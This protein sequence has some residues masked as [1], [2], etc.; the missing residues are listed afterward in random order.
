ME[1]IEGT[2]DEVAAASERLTATVAKVTDEDLRRPSRLPG[3]TRGHLLAHLVRNTDSCWNLLEWART[4]SEF[5][6]Y[7]DD[8]ARDAGIAASASRPADELRAELRI[9]V[10]RF[11]LQAATLPEPA[12][13]YLV[14]ARAGW[15]HP[16]W[17]VLRRRLREIYAHLVDLDMGYTAA[18]WP[19]SYVR[20]EL[21][22]TLAALRLDGGLAAGRVR[23]TDMDVD[24]RLGDGPEVSAPA[25]DLLAWLTG[26]GTPAAAWPAPPSWPRTAPDW[27]TA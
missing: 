4:G 16:A 7:P 3:W 24:V 1:E 26:R 9:A 18:D 22:D 13:Q 5:P 8:R 20:W 27:R 23:A 10:Q 2:L 19:R 12:W 11:A 21:T 15:A 17:Y 6:Q 25:H 14:R